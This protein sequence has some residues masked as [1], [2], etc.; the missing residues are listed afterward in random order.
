MAH[1]RNPDWLDLSNTPEQIELAD[2]RLKLLPHDKLVLSRGITEE[3]MAMSQKE[4]E[5]L[6]A[7]G[8]RADDVVTH[9]EL[10]QHIWKQSEIDFPLSKTMQ[11]TVN[12]L[13]SRMPDVL[14][15]PRRGVIRTRR[16]VGYYAV[17]HL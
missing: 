16:N 2:R 5:I 7:C 17:K 12:H 15:D 6:L 9:L 10:A 3:E 11:V 1:R 14:G 13:R 4:Y 8:L